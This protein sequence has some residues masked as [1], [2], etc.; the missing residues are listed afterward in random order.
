V[1]IIK[2]GTYTEKEGKS[3]NSGEGVPESLRK[4]PV[5]HAQ[6]LH[7]IAAMKDNHP[8]DGNSPKAIEISCAH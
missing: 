3:N 1:D 5:N 2:R 4:V 7:V 8:N 6:H